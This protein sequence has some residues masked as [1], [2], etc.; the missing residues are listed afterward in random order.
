MKE[1]IFTNEEISDFLRSKIEKR[2][3]VKILNAYVYT[4]TEEDNFEKLEFHYREDIEHPVDKGEVFP[5]DVIIEEMRKVMPKVKIATN[6]KE[7]KNLVVDTP[8]NLESTVNKMGETVTQI[9][10]FSHGNKRT[11]HGIISSSIKDGAFTK[12]MT[13]DGRMLMI[14]ADNVDC[15]EVFSEKKY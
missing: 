15:I 4:Y 13:K 9:I 11:F 2:D 8:V 1:L 7:D 10:H 3:G 14:N 12:M 6:K 5:L